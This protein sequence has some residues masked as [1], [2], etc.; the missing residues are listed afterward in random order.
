MV[1]ILIALWEVAKPSVDVVQG[2]LPLLNLSRVLVV[3]FPWS[4]REDESKVSLN[5]FSN[6]QIDTERLVLL[7][8]WEEY[9]YYCDVMSAAMAVPTCPTSSDVPL[10]DGRVGVKEGIV[11][12]GL[13][14]DVI[15]IRGYRGG[16]DLK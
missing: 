14:I 12:A 4:V 7:S 13:G 2:L 11:I 10:Q 8:L 16:V 15:E 5:V 6:L 1:D 9:C 3:D